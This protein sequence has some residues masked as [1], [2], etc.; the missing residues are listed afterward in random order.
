MIDIIVR[1]VCECPRLRP[2]EEVKTKL[3]FPKPNPKFPTEPLNLGQKQLSLT[4]LDIF[5]D[6]ESFIYSN[7]ASKR[8]NHVEFTHG[9]CITRYTVAQLI[10]TY[11]GTVLTCWKSLHR[12]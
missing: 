9:L 12:G 1:L 2:V 5:S 10:C 3:S 11:Q 6:K 4:H 7:V 8:Y